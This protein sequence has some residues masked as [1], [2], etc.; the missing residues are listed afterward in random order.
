MVSDPVDPAAY[1][2]FYPLVMSKQLWKMTIEILDIPNKHGDFP[3]RYVNL[4]EG[5]IFENSQFGSRSSMTLSLKQRF[6]FPISGPLVA[7]ASLK[8]SLARQR[9]RGLS[10]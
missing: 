6:F 4:P 2:I 7:W 10:R 5:T 8:R 1:H 3:V 9:F